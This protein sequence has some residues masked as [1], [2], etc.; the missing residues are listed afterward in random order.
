MNQHLR[1]IAEEPVKTIVLDGLSVRDV[2]LGA[3]LVLALVLL[4]IALT[5]LR[6]KKRR[7]ASEAKGGDLTTNPLNGK[8]RPR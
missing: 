4:V 6:D 1:L 5:K 7:R 3:A 2:A 8:E